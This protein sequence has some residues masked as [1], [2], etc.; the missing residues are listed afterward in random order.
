VPPRNDGWAW[1][2][3]CT[4]LVLWPALF[5]EGDRAFAHVTGGAHL[6][7][8]SRRVFYRL[9]EADLQHQEFTN[10]EDENRSSA[11]L[12][13]SRKLDDPRADGEM[14]ESFWPA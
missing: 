10:I 1:L 7:I 6:G 12:H 14:V 11:Q 9:G 13:V 3:G 8:E 2:F 5:V 4:G